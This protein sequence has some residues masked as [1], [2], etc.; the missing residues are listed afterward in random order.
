MYFHDANCEREFFSSS[1]VKNHV[2]SHTA[3]SNQIGYLLAQIR[4]LFQRQGVFT[5]AQDIAFPPD[6]VKSSCQTSSFGSKWLKD[7]NSQI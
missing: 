5:R 2:D 7:K 6:P 4:F 3:E 1:V